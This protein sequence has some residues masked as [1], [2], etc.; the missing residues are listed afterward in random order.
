M[1]FAIG[2]Y[3]FRHLSV[4][5]GN[6]AYNMTFSWAR[7]R[8]GLEHYMGEWIWRMPP[9]FAAPILL[10][11]RTRTAAWLAL[12]SLLALIPVVFLPTRSAFVSHL[13]WCFAVLA[14]AV[15]CASLRNP[16][17]PVSMAVALTL[18]MGLRDSRENENRMLSDS[19][20]LM[21]VAD[22]V[23]GQRPHLPKGA[24]VYFANDS[25]EPQY[26]DLTFLVRLSYGDPAIH[27]RRGKRGD[28][29]SPN[30]V[31]QL[32]TDGET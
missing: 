25:F 31:L 27:V 20:R 19:W 13:A 8:E 11:V 1:A 21:R 6:E 18:W 28:L 32:E 5:G 2:K 10:T 12:G 22:F 23:K 24:Q 29:P 14:F 9:L 15:G 3:G 16:R 26:Y 4:F 30:D 7:F 17:I